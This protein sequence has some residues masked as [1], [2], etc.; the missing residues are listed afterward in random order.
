MVK[1]MICT[2]LLLNLVLGIQA[3]H[4][5]MQE[6]HSG[7]M[8][9]MG[10]SHAFSPSLPMNRDG[11]GTSWLPD[12]AAMYASKIHSGNWLFMLHGNLFL[13]YNN[14]DF[15][16][17]GS[18]GGV[19][20]DAPSMVML[21]GQHRVGEKGLFHFGTM[22]SLDAAIAGGSG[23]P[24]LFQTGESWKGK[25]LIDRQHPHDL[26]SEL[27]ISYAYSFSPEIDL[28]IYLGYPGEPALGP[29]TFIHRPSG[30]FN[31]DAPISHHWMDATHITFGVAT[32]GFRYNQFR[33]EGSSFTGR[34]PD[35]NRFNFDKPRMDSRS[36]RLS[37]NPNGNWAFQASHGFLK[38]PEA[39][40]PNEDIYRTTTSAICSYPLGKNIFFDATAVYGLNKIKKEKGSNAALLEATFRLKRMA[41]YGRYE[42]I[43][44]TAEEL[45][46]ND[47]E[48]G[49]GSV[50]SVN[51]F[52]AGVGY[53]LIN[54]VKIRIAAGGQ[55]S[56]FHA[57][58]RL[59]ILYGKNP[60]SMEFYLHLYPGLMMH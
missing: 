6:Q 40:H 9:S 4:Q 52:T 20:F 14:Q 34:E 2:L 58:N 24:L 46:L 29:V 26:F 56:I 25:P 57:D 36:V 22:F 23:Y 5:D 13:R 51:A 59:D 41:F 53:D 48:F 19:K 37:Y 54:T 47:F 7:M 16:K 35:E 8:E 33:L 39:L 32:I 11:S 45:D 10:M 60:L 38:S 30:M 21:M 18:R 28:F 15:T 43:Q 1:K 49:T 3:Q 55:F 50:F 17:K 42:W 44:K 27:S 12:S 31:P